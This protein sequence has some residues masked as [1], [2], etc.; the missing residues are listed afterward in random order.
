MNSLSATIRGTKTKGEVN[1]LR[2][3]GEVP[4]IL[5]GGKDQNQKLKI[6][7][8]EIKNLIEKENFLSN[9]ISLNLEGESLNVLPREVSFDVITDEPIHVDFLRIVKG[10]K[11]VLEIPVKFINT[12]NSPGIKRGGVLNIVR[13][14]VELN[15]P[16]EKIPTELVVDLDGLDIG[17][18]IKI[19]SVSLPN[20][21]TPTIQGRDFVIA[22]VAAP[23]IVKEPEKPAEETAAEGTEGAEVTEGTEATTET[24]SDKSTEGEKTKEADKKTDKKEDKKP[25]T[26]KK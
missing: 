19:S 11:I 3:N 14:K 23:T 5:Y 4:C 26:E 24:S 17:S 15:C 6:S 18:S 21:V 13:R 22:T 7:K 10:E 25:Q 12:E 8:K 16:T 20:N 9:V 2:S 1:R